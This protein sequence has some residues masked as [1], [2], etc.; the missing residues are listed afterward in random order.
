[1]STAGLTDLDDRYFRLDLHCYLLSNQIGNIYVIFDLDRVNGR[2][3]AALP[4]QA[5]DSQLLLLS[6]TTHVN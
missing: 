6:N 5:F 1:M 2:L 3:R 4:W